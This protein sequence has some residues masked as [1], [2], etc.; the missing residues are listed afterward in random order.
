MASARKRSVAQILI[1]QKS[2][3]GH[4]TSSGETGENTTR[5]IETGF[6]QYR[7]SDIAGTLRASGGA[8]G[9]GSETLVIHG[10]QDPIV[11]RDIAHCLGRNGGS[12][13]V[14]FEIK[15]A[16]A[17]RIAEQPISPT[18]KARMGTGG[19]NV[20]CVAIAGN[21]IGRS[22]E[23]G[24]NGKG[25]NES[26]ICYTLTSTDQ[27]AVCWNGDATPKT[28]LNKSL[29]LRASQGGEGIG[30]AHKGVIRKLTPIGCERLQGFPDDWT[31][32]PYRNKPLG[33]CP[34]SPRYKAIG[35]SMAVPVMQWIGLRLVEYLNC[36]SV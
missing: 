4:S 16:E 10:T 23:N 24:G 32:I 8:L 35:N 28:S 31:K 22:L 20:P 27:H 33:Q 30:I 9:D 15:G 6:A 13:N 17:L 11:N 36:E 14:L 26:G 12:E 3:P 2:V 29:T 25:F 18:L 34:D 7:Q 1:E 5:V 19:N 21:I